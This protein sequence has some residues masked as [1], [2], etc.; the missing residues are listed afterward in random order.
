MKTVII[1]LAFSFFFTNAGSGQTVNVGGK[2]VDKNTLNPLNGVNISL[3]NNDLSIGTI[4]NQ[5]GEFRLW[6]LPGD[7]LRIRVSH[8][9]YKVSLIDVAT[10]KN[11]TENTLFVIELEKKSK[12]GRSNTNERKLAFLKKKLVAKK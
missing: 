10:L 11:P 8:S 9:G 7:S 1:L 12:S 6:N 3:E 4:T 5:K 2:V